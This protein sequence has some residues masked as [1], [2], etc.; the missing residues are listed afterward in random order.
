MKA[1]RERDDESRGSPPP[2]AGYDALRETAGVLGGEARTLVRVWGDRAREMIGGLVTNDVA[3]LEPG[4]AL[5]AFML[6]PKGRPLAE[7]R[8]LVLDPAELWLDMPAACAAAVLEHLQRYLPPIYARFEAE[9]ERARLS[10]VGPRYA[11]VLAA[12]AGVPAAD[13]LAPLQ[14]ADLPSPGGH[15]VRRESAEGP[16]ADLYVPATR[17]PE[18]LGDLARA[19]RES[20]GGVASPEAFEVWRVERGL[21]VYGA[22]IDLDVLPQETG[23]EERA[24]DY[25]KGCYVGQEVVARIHFRGHVNHRL[26]GLRFPDA[27]APSPGAELYEEGR[28]RGTVTSVVFSPRLGSIGLGYVR[29]EVPDGTRLAVGSGE[30]AVAEV[31]DLPFEG[32]APPG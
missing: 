20:G 28:A 29:R 12:G 11:E 13:A 18:L 4:R 1:D 19:A 21:P 25:D 6:T 10:V 15:L 22:E 3:G 31:T 14:I 30:G 2:P 17:A 8:A 23:Q 5:Y 7:L 9:E 32:S 16:G 26:A 24:I 27:P